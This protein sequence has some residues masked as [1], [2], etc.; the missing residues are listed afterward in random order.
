MSAT[1]FTVIGAGAGGLAMA[2]HLA[3]QGQPVCIYNRGDERI[4]KIRET[5]GVHM[6]GLLN[7]IFAVDSVTQDIEQAIDFADV[8]FVVVPAHAHFDLASNAAPFLRD[9]QMIVL[10]PGRTGGALE[11]ARIVRAARPECRAAI[12]EAQTIL[13]TCRPCGEDAG[14]DVIAAKRDVPL[15]ALP[16]S[17]TVNVIGVIGEVFPQFSEAES[18]L[19]T[20]LG[21]VGAVLHPAPTLLNAGWIETERTE[22]LYYYEG[23]TPIV[24][25]LIERVD[26][27]RVGVAEALGVATFSVCDWLCRVYGATGEHLVDAIRTNPAYRGIQAPR[28]LEH[29]YIL[30]DVPTGLVPIASLGD[31]VG[32]ETPTINLIIDLA[33]A[34]C[35][36]DFR[37]CG[38]TIVSLGLADLSLS[39]IHRLVTH[40]DLTETA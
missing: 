34:M 27:E 18:V 28:S 24:G 25:A 3:E 19:A 10:C 2:G 12:A 31:L 14:V 20:S 40:G 33:S 8:I 35:D 37:E 29:R 17:E 4:R 15:A 36:V 11:F 5:G 9:D 26:R 38:R 39:E 6:R 23:I 21:N 13:H 7:G 22:F 16:A 30:E 1:R 32:V